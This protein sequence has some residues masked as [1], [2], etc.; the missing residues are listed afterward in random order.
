MK[1]LIIAVI[2]ASLSGYCFAATTYYVVT[3][4]PDSH[5]PYT[6]WGIAGTNII[7]VVNAA[8]TNGSGNTVLV[9]NGTYVLTN[10]ITITNTMTLQ[11]VHGREYTFLNGNYPNTTNRCISAIINNPIIDGFTISNAWATNSLVLWFINSLTYF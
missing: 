7:D 4:N 8:L 10:E 6:N 5:D 1:H 11:G 9:S 3:N 2:I